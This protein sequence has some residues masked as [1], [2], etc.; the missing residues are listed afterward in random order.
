[1]LGGLGHHNNS[2]DWP[3]LHDFLHT[4]KRIPHIP[5]DHSSHDHL[6]EQWPV[7]LG[8]LFAMWYKAKIMAVQKEVEVASDTCIS[9]STACL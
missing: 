2:L 1:M 9:I 5:D 8:D 4:I 7:L 3:C 6:N